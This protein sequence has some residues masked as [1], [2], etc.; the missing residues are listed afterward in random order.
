[1]VF[2]VALYVSLSLFGLGLV[3]KLVSWF[4]CPIGGESRGISPAR[5]FSSMVRG[6]TA[7]VFGRR[8]L[9]L[10]KI[11]FLDFQSYIYSSARNLAL[12]GE[13]GLPLLCLCQC[14]YGTLRYADILLRQNEALFKDIT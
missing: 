2:K 10:G 11:F 14:C 5:R 7:V 9:L 1:M 6:V 13:K 3:Y 4:R 8:V 12:V